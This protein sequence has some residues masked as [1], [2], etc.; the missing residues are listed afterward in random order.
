MPRMKL[1]VIPK[2]ALIGTDGIEVGDGNLNRL[3][4]PGLQD[5]LYLESIDREAVL[6]LGMVCNDK[7]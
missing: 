6:V 7:F 5:F 1:A 2:R 3:A 4:L